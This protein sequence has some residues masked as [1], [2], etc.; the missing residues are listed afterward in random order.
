M[1]DCLYRIVYRSKNLM[2]SDEPDNTAMLST[3][4]HKSRIRNAQQLV[5]GALLYNSG[6]FAQVLEGPLAQVQSVFERIQQDERHNDVIILECAPTAQR[7]F[8][9]W[10]MAHVAPMREEQSQAAEMVLGRAQDAQ[11][12]LASEVLHLL[13]SL[14]VQDC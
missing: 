4:L 13:R 5:T 10:S 2:I 11:A 6:Y 7:Y 1:T 9:E 8:S 14:V 3:I 12:E